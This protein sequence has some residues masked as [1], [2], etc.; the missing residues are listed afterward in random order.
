MPHQ[1]VVVP[2]PTT[3]TRNMNCRAVL[4]GLGDGNEL[5]IARIE[6]RERW[7]AVELVIV[8]TITV[9]ARDS[10]ALARELVGLV[11]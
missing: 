2:L 6:M 3:V 4:A 8:F 1:A 5:T 9:S 10:Y 11:P 7:I